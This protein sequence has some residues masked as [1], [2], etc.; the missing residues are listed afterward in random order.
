MRRYR[1][2]MKNITANNQSSG[3]FVYNRNVSQFGMN[4]GFY[5]T[6]LEMTFF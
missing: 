5:Y 3:R 2:S 1:N 6:K 4:G